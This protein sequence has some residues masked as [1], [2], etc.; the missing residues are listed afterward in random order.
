MTMSG[1]G[2][3]S[4]KLITFSYFYRGSPEKNYFFL[5]FLAVSKKNITFSY[6]YRESQKNLL[7]FLT[8]TES[9]KKSF[10]FFLLLPKT[11]KNLLL[12]LTFAVKKSNFWVLLFFAETFGEKMQFY[13]NSFS[14]KIVHS[15]VFQIQNMFLTTVN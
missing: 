7:L 10:Y 11:A 2:K 13:S 15:S 14:I 5:L 8:F 1:L 12:F 4:V 6:F 3:S 9:L